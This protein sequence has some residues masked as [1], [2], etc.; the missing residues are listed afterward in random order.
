MRSMSSTKDI[1]IATW[2]GLLVERDPTNGR[3]KTVKKKTRAEARSSRQAHEDTE[4]MD[5]DQEPP[6]LEDVGNGKVPWQRLI[7]GIEGFKVTM[8]E[9][10]LGFT[11]EIRENMIERV[12]VEH[13]RNLAVEKRGKVKDDGDGDERGGSEKYS[14][15]GGG[16]VVREERKVRRL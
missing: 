13:E 12:R 7:T 8:N 1:G 4:E 9:M 3:R 6:V 10:S 5:F 15:G 16:E 14:G 11:I 2:N